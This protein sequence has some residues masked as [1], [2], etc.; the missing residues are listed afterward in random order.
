M[1]YYKNTEF[2]WRIGTKETVA[3]ILTSFP[4]QN[5]VYVIKT[6]EE[7]DIIMKIVKD[8]HIPYILKIFDE[9]GHLVEKHEQKAKPQ[10]ITMENVAELIALDEE[11]DDLIKKLDAEL[12]HQQVLARRRE[13]R[14]LKKLKEKGK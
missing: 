3:L 14:K 6:Q 10:E 8:P 4:A 9:N 2:Q 11:R 12:K 7:L 13:L 5:K 1:G